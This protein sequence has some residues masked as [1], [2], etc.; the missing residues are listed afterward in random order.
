[1][2]YANGLQR[3]YA[4]VFLVAIGIGYGRE[5]RSG[6]GHDLVGHVFCPLDIDY[7]FEQ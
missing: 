6:I 5:L 1:M 3:D 4:D 2:S 7:S